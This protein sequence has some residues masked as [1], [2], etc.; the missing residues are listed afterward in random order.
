MAVILLR[1]VMED[2]GRECNVEGI[3]VERNAI[4]LHED[5]AFLA[6]KTFSTQL[7]TSC[8]GIGAAMQFGFHQLHAT[9]IH[10][11]RAEP[12]LPALADRADGAWGPCGVARADPA[13]SGSGGSDANRR[14][15]CAVRRSTPSERAAGQLDQRWRCR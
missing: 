10:R 12:A 4:A 7:D 14:A 1:N 8:R 2:T 5:K 13:R 15:D 3:G 11:H 9:E 6:G